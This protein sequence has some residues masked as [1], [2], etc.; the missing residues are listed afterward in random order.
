MFENATSQREK[1]ERREE[2]GKEGGGADSLKC[3]LA[4]LSVDSIKKSDNNDKNYRVQPSDKINERY[5]QIFNR[6]SNE[7]IHTWHTHM[8]HTRTHT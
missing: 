6:L 4:K 7:H 5:E 2:E 1:G 3:P 8:T